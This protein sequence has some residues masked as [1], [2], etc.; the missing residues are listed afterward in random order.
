MTEEGERARLR[1]LVRRGYDTISM[2]YRSDDGQANTDSVETT[3]TYLGWVAELSQLLIPAARV[4]DLGCGAGVPATKALVERG[5]Q[6]TGV[7]I[8]AVQIGRARELVP[9]AYFE[10]ADMATW[11]APEESFDAVVSL[12]ALIHVPL[13]DQRLL[14]PRIRRWLVPGGYLLAIVGSGHWRGL[15]PYM[16]AE[17]FWEHADTE[18]YLQWLPDAGL[19]PVWHRFIQ[20]GDA[21]HTLV[22]ARAT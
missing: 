18:T 17:M 14:F 19:E 7:D 8:S 1:D 4:L 10:L 21:G 9:G 15:E 20:E 3:A 6:V 2:T 12:Y 16:G 22:L 13:P 11:D 5:F